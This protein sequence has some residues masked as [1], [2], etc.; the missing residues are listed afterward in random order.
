MLPPTFKTVKQPFGSKVCGAA[1][2]AMVV[3]CTLEE[4]QA[5]MMPSFHEKKRF[6]KTREIL[7]F[8]GGHGVICGMTF[9]VDDGLL[10]HDADIKFSVNMQDIYAIVVVESSVYAGYSHYV[11]W[12]GKNVHDP[13]PHVEEISNLEDYVVQDVYPLT[14]VDEAPSEP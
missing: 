7:K 9:S 5:R 12:D 2:A 11:F 10:W 1:L 14:Y 13:N 6:Y 4:A 8:I 3:G